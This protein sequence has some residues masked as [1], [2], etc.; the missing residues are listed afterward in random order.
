MDMQE[1]EPWRDSADLRWLFLDLNSYFAS[2]EQQERPG[3]R[4][5]PVIVV[6][7]ES[8]HTSAI[9]ASYEAKA[10]GVKTNMKV[11]EALRHCPDLRVVLAR[12]DLYVDYHHRIVDV[13]EE[14]LHVSK[15]CSIDEVACELLGPERLTANAVRIARDIQGTILARIGPCLRSS[16]GL[17]P[18]RLL[19]KVAS[20][21]KKP[22]GLT[23]LGRERLP[24]PLFALD[25]IDLPGIGINMARRLRQAGI[26]TVEALWSLTPRQ[27]RDVWGSVEGERLSMGLHGQDPVEPEAVRRSVGHSHVLPMALRDMGAA[28]LVVRRLLL[29]AAMRMRRMEHSAR[30]MSVGIRLQ[31]G[32]RL[33]AQRRFQPCADSFAFLRQ[34][35]SAWAELEAAARGAIVKKVGVTLDGLIPDTLILPD[36]FTQNETVMGQPGRGL[37]LSRTLDRLNR[38]FGR[39]TVNVGMTVKPLSRYVG[40]KIAF[41]RIPDRRDFLE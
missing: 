18:S 8:E 20:D 3:L 36:L 17:A 5:K 16:V 38:R 27:V 2:V 13:I 39:D 40:A 21:M 32:E 29:M 6:P 12:H 4:G 25:L 7:V 14:H 9:A 10:F 28:R 37:R 34:L 30:A 15:V 23:V 1:D 26:Q 31:S 24:G 41:N 33:H 22:M 19:A 11:R 35:E